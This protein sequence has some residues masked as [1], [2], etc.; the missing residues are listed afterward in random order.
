MVKRNKSMI[1]VIRTGIDASLKQLDVVSHNI[2]N[3]K[4]TGFKTSRASFEDVYARKLTLGEPSK[5]GHGSRSSD[6]STTQTQGA[7]KE[8][9][10]VLDLAIEGQGMFVV[11]KPG[12]DLTERA[13]F[14]RDGSFGLDKDGFIINSQGLRLKS[15]FMQDIPAPTQIEVN[16]RT[17]FVKDVAVDEAGIIKLQYGNN[18]ELVVGQIGMAQFA[19]ANHLQETGDNLFRATAKSGAPKIEKPFEGNNGKVVP[20]ALEMSNVNMTSE[21]STMLQAQ[22]AFSGA[23]RLLQTEAEMTR[24][25]IG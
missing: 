6:M 11:G 14:T 20:G 15:I 12:D 24:R 18:Q 7:L 23:S 3:A 5:I 17:F 4:T 19:D 22:Q 21:L 1:S 10:Q 25:L 9:G 8:T 16:G 13:Q 2:A